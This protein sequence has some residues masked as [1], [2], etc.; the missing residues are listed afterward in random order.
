MVPT[1]SV[2]LGE[3]QVVALTGYIQSGENQNRIP[4]ARA[5]GGMSRDFDVEGDGHSWRRPVAG[6]RLDVRERIA[7]EPPPVGE[8]ALRP[9]P[10]AIAITFGALRLSLRLAVLA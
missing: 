3:S 10:P 2:W 1:I 6:C 4:I 7:G 9:G 5:S 8:A